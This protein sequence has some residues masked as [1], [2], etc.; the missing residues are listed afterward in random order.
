MPPLICGMPMDVLILIVSNKSTKGD[1]GDTMV[2]RAGVIN[3][4]QFKGSIKIKEGPRTARSF[5]FQ[6]MV[7]PGSVKVVVNKGDTK[8][9]KVGGSL[10]LFFFGKGL[11]RCIHA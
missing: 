7:I 3:V 5:T 10:L 8:V 2:V 4:T 9:V 1:I 6:G 11:R